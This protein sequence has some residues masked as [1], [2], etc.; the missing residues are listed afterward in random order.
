MRDHLPNR[1][2]VALRRCLAGHGHIALHEPWFE[3]NEGNYVQECIATGWVSTAGA[4]VERFEQQLTEITGVKHAV[5]TVNGT[6]ALH[7]CLKLAGVRG[8][9][10]VLT[11]ALCFVAT[12]N[13]ISYCGA[14]P[15]FADSEI[16]TLGLDPAKLSGHLDEIAEIRDGVCTNRLTGRRIAAVVPMH[17]FGHP[18]DLDALD[19][20]CQRYR[21]TLVED[22]A[23][24][25]GSYYKGKH[26]GG[27]GLLSALS[28]NGNKLVT[29]GG[30]GAILT[31]DDEL[32]RKARHLTTTAR[33]VD[34]WHF[35]HDEVGYNYRLPNL[36]AALGVAQLEQ[37]ETF[38]YRKRALAERYRAAFESAR[39]V[40]Y[41][42][43]PSFARSNYWL[44]TL[45]LE[46]EYSGELE[47]ILEVLN[48]AGLGARPAWT[49][50][51]RLPMYQDCPRMDLGVAED[52]AARIVNIP[53]SA[54]L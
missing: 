7:M 5:A 34:R 33:L 46:P 24:A 30:G 6:A 47:A 44:N 40:R 54:F 20:V 13:A 18:A 28:F 43:E 11:P 19:E 15:H 17:T 2:L 48:A 10:E 4:F 37:L 39:D 22:A 35:S 21:M 45:L 1:I 3:G 23:E 36:N 32:A 53:S 49:L 52:L 29:T 41:F 9:D 38:V 27:Q 31:N 50:M 26:V 42:V 12:A 8:G 16:G 51:H 25:L 14:V